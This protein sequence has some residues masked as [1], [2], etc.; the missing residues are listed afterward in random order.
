MSTHPVAEVN[1]PPVR[2]TDS[3]LPFKAEEP[4]MKNAV[5]EMRG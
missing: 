5:Q 4:T 2:P 1:S 3:P